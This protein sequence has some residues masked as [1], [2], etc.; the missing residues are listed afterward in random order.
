MQ[1]TDF[2]GR[3]RRFVGIDDDADEQLDTSNR[4][5]VESSDELLVVPD[6]LTDALVTV[7]GEASTSA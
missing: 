1:A 3:L 2:P 6:E 4:E 7:P 5:A